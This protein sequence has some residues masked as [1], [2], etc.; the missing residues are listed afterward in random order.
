MW[1]PPHQYSTKI[2]GSLLC[3]SKS[4]SNLCW[5]LLYDFLNVT[6]WKYNVFCCQCCQSSQKVFVLIKIY[7]L[8]SSWFLKSRNKCTIWVQMNFVVEMVNWRKTSHYSDLCKIRKH[9]IH[10]TRLWKIIWS[11]LGLIAKSSQYF[12]FF[13]KAHVAYETENPEDLWDILLWLEH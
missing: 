13:L 1:A 9:I 6:H 8:D 11:H 7:F 10:R 12:F 3:W 5:R 2:R 4:S